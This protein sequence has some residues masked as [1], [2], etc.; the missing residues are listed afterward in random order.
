MGRSFHIQRRTT[1]LVEISLRGSLSGYDVAACDNELRAQLA[2]VKPTS[3]CAVVDLSGVMDY[4][5]EAREALVALQ[6]FLGGKASVTAY[7]G[8]SAEQR[9]L[10]LWVNHMV[11][12]QVIQR[13]AELEAALA[14]LN[15]DAKPITGVRPLAAARD[16]RMRQK[17]IA[18]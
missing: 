10:S 14:W 13:F 17:K 1:G 8:D 16:V 7:I 12:G 4:T 3:L 2:L 11:H 5:L 15:G 6:T 9:G 18:G